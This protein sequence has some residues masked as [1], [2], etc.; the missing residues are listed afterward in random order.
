M[1][2]YDP[3][4]EIASNPFPIISP[5][6]N[7]S[8]CKPKFS[9][10]SRLGLGPPPSSR[11]SSP[12]KRDHLVVS[13]TSALP[14]QLEDRPI[15]SRPT[16]PTRVFSSSSI[17]TPPLAV[18]PSTPKR[19]RDPMDILFI[20]PRS[21][22]VSSPARTERVRPSQASSPYR[23]MNVQAALYG[24]L[25]LGPETVAVPV[26][27]RPLELREPRQE[28]ILLSKSRLGCLVL[29][30]DAVRDDDLHIPKEFGQE[31][32]IK[33]IWPGYNGRECSSRVS[34]ASKL[35]SFDTRLVI[36]DKIKKMFLSFVRTVADTKI[37]QRYSKFD[38]LKCTGND[39]RVV[40]LEH[41]F[42]KVYQVAFT[43]SDTCLSA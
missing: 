8:R 3:A 6:A 16:T 32:T 7:T 5:R 18:P 10:I 28:D 26:P 43:V 24:S 31:I 37:D 33:F 4:R 21:R 1:P 42:D 9:E 27:Q 23:R 40:K 25:R 2:R 20:L 11:P 34:W 35:S 36:L 22:G 19:R 38:L 13:E 17:S 41:R 14:L 15:L 30:P 29:S 12:L 39:V